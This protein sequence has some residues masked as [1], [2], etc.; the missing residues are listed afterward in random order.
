MEEAM[1]EP[2]EY[3]FHLSIAR[4][5]NYEKKKKKKNIVWEGCGRLSVPRGWLQF[6]QVDLGRLHFRTRWQECSEKRLR[7]KRRRSLLGGNPSSRGF[8]GKVSRG[9]KG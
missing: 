7:M 1:G 2:R 3:Q 5:K 4:L 6:R 9:E 8:C